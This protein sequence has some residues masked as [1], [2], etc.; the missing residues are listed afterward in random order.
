MYN[1]VK[2]NILRY[3]YFTSDE[4]NIYQV[5]LVLYFSRIIVLNYVNVS[6]EIV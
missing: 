4:K 6:A 5:N 1:C 3:G 2:D